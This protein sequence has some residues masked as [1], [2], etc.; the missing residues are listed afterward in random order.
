M[1]EIIEIFLNVSVADQSSEVIDA[2]SMGDDE[3][4]LDDDFDSP[5]PFY[6]SAKIDE[7]K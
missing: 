7:E 1:L 3:A 2:T 5:P 4:L 6:E